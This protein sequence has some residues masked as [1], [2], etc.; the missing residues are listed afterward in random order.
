MSRMFLTVVFAALCALT[1]PGA[2]VADDVF[3]TS[4]RHFFIPFQI[5]DSGS[6]GVRKLILY[7]S[8]DEGKSWAAAAFGKPDDRGFKY[9]SE[10]DGSYWFAVQSIDNDGHTIPANMANTRPML[11]V[12]VS[13]SKAGTILQNSE[14]RVVSPPPRPIANQPGPK[15]ADDSTNFQDIRRQL[16]RLR[17]RIRKLERQ[18]NEM[19]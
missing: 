11:K 14:P 15:K 3:V 16:R 7:V 12:L 1:F 9:L 19:D 2:G 4:T 5:A 8:T 6:S 10:K 18:L 13:T 17:A